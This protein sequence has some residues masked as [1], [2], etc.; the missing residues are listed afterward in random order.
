MVSLRFRSDYLCYLRGKIQKNIV[1]CF[2]FFIKERA[3]TTVPISAEEG[4]QA[5]P[6][7]RMQ[8]SKQT[9]V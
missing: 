8:G 9:R 1:I 6:Q 5:G 2:R 4:V 7:A 3:K